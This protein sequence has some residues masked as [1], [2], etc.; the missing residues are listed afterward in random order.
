ML[1]RR[2]VAQAARALD[3][4]KA[5]GRR[6]VVEV[7]ETKLDQSDMCNCVLGQLYG[8]YYAESAWRFRRRHVDL[9]LAFGVDVSGRMPNWTLLTYAWR[10]EI[11][12]RRAELARLTNAPTSRT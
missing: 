2:L 1:Y 10:R 5:E 6:W 7:D 11:R 9:A 8:D 12:R 3:A 4:Y